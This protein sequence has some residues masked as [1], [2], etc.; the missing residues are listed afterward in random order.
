MSSTTMP[1]PK[2]KTETKTE[3]ENETFIDEE[4]TAEQRALWDRIGA[5][6]TAAKAA[7]VQNGRD[8]TGVLV[9]HDANCIC[10]GCVSEEL[11]MACKKE[12][13]TPTPFGQ[14]YG[15]AYQA[16]AE[17]FSAGEWW[18][19]FG[20]ELMAAEN[21]SAAHYHANKA[22]IDA[23]SAAAIAAFDRREK[24]ARVAIREGASRTR[25]GPVEIRRLAQPCKFLYN[26]QGTPARPTTMHVSTECWSHETGV[27][28]WAHPAMPARAAMRLSN[29]TVV[30]AARAIPADPL[31]DAHWMTDRLFRPVVAGENRFAAAA[32]D[33]R[34]PAPERRD[35][36]RGGGRDL[37]ARDERVAH[38]ASGYRGDRR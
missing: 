11:W 18:S 16:E 12:C 34:P 15:A 23:E 37:H 20:A 31:W 30:P 6:W 21:A 4:P 22:R 14:R 24:A 8:W 35:E 13:E 27:C 3:N 5:S 10:N 33:A 1:M 9:E 7:G 2:T 25:H 26:C 17:R 38:Y 36:R 28:P 19:I 29:G 32:A